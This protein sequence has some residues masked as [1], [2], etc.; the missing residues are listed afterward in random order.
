MRRGWET[1]RHMISGLLV[2]A[3]LMLPILPAHT[4]TVIGPQSTVPCHHHGEGATAGAASDHRQQPCTQDHCNHRA[5]C[6]PG[7]CL[8]FATRLIEAEP[9]PGAAF[10]T[11]AIYPAGVDFWLRGSA[12]RPA[13]PPPRAFV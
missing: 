12:P 9:V 6:C 2:L 1:I 4:Q 11:L 3:L 13:L 7:A 8:T 10:S 5:L